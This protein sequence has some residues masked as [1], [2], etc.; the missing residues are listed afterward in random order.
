LGGSVA[1]AIREHLPEVELALWG[2][3]VEA[4]EQAKALGLKGATTSMEEAVRDADVIIL[5]TPV[6][7]MSKVVEQLKPFVSGAVLMTDV[8]SVKRFPH[9]QLRPILK[10]TEVEFVGSHPMAGSEQAGIEAARKDL[11][12]GAACLVTNDEG[13][14]AEKVDV[15]KG[16][17]KILGCRVREMSAEDHDYAIARISHF[18]H[19]LASMGATV[20]LAY[21]DIAEL[22]GG[23]LRDTTRVAAGDPHLWTEILMENGDALQRSIAESIAELAKIQEML[24]ISDRDS[25]FVYLEEAKRK[26]E[27]I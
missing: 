5:A 7:V 23:G 26:R 13:V 17:W 15:V 4:I 2:R 10:G 6:G 22:A 3:R 27:L 24:R 14:A 19:M 18:P 12:N 25:L 21:E 9:A 11:I 20:G 1:L 8:G 16:L